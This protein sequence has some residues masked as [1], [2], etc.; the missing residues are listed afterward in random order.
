MK[1]YRDLDIYNDSKKLAI[2]THKMSLLLPK[3]TYQKL[4]DEY[5]VLNKRINKLIQWVE[6]N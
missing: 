4:H 2:E 5:D 3:L 6:S 1:S